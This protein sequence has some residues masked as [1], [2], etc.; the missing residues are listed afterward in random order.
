M[1]KKIR[2]A[3]LGTCFLVPG[4]IIEYM[5]VIIW[6]SDLP[7]ISQVLGQKAP[8]ECQNDMEIQTSKFASF[9]LGEI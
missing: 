5:F 8:V 4:I 1:F 9:K 3:N 7:E 6:F 2:Y